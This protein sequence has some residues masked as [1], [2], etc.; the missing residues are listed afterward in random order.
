MQSQLVPHYSD[1][2]P[3]RAREQIVPLAWLRRLVGKSHSFSSIVFSLSLSLSLFHESHVSRIYGGVRSRGTATSHLPT[4]PRTTTSAR[5]QGLARCS[6]SNVASF[7]QARVEKSSSNDGDRTSTRSTVASMIRQ[8][9]ARRKNRR[10]AAEKRRKTERLIIV[11]RASRV[12]VTSRNNLGR[13]RVNAKSGVPIVR[14]GEKTK[15]SSSSS[16]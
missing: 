8:T 3:W 1:S 12:N 11:E 13:E 14:R 2:V 7:P 9:R 16:M 4:Q 5:T 6:R 15:Q 10:E